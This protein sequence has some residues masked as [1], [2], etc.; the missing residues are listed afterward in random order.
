MRDPVSRV[1]RISIL[2]ALTST[3]GL[4]L[5]NATVASEA[6]E[7]AGD[8]VEAWLQNL[9][10]GFAIFAEGIAAGQTCSLELLRASGGACVISATDALGGVM[11]TDRDGRLVTSRPD[12]ADALPMAWVCFHGTCAGGI[13]LDECH[14]PDDPLASA[15]LSCGR[16]MQTSVLLGPQAVDSPPSSQLSLRFVETGS[17]RSGPAY[18][19]LTPTL[20][21]GDSGPRPLCTVVVAVDA[22]D[23]ELAAL[24]HARDAVNSSPDC[25]AAGV[26][27]EL[28]TDP[29]SSA[30][31][32]L[33]LGHVAAAATG[34]GDSFTYL[35]LSAPDL[36]AAQLIPAVHVV[37]PSAF[38]FALADLGPPEAYQSQVMAVV[39]HTVAGGATGDGQVTVVERTPVGACSIVTPTFAGQSAEML[40]RDIHLG[41]QAPGLPGP[42]SC[43]ASRNP[44]DV[45]FSGNRIITTLP[46]QIEIYV[47]DPGVGHTIQ[48]EGLGNV[49]PGAYCDDAMVECTGDGQAEI[50]LDASRSSDPDGDVLTFEWYEDYGRADEIFLGRGRTLA[51]PFGYGGHDI[52]VVVRDALG[53]QSAGGCHVRVA[54]TTPPTVVGSTVNPAVLYPANHALVGVTTAIDAFDTCSTA[55]ATLVTLTSSEPDDALGP[56]DGATKHDIQDAIPYTPDFQFHLRAERDST[57]AGRSYSAT[58][59]VRDDAGNAVSVDLTVEVPL[60]IGGVTD[61]ITVSV[62]KSVDPA[63]APTVEVVWTDTEG[64]REYNVARGDVR[65]ISETANHIYL[66]PVECLE[67]R[68]PTRSTQ[69]AGAISPGDVFFYL[70]EPIHLE[71]PGGF[72]GAGLGKPR[73]VDPCFYSGGLELIPDPERDSI[74]PTAGGWLVGVSGQHLGT[75]LEDFGER[76]VDVDWLGPDLFQSVQVVNAGVTYGTPAFLW[77]DHTETD[78]LS[79]LEK[80]DGRILDLE[81]QPRPSMPPLFTVSIIPNTGKRAKAWWWDYDLTPEEV[82]DAIDDYGM[83]II[84]LDAYEVLGE[85]KY[86]YVGVANVGVDA[87]AWW[88]YFNIGPD[89]VSQALADNNARLMD[90]E[91]HSNGNFSVVMVADDG[92]AW[93]WGA[94][95]TAQ[96]VGTFVNNKGS[97]LIDLERLVGEGEPRYAFVSIDNLSTDESKRL[98]SVVEQ[99]FDQSEFGPFFVTRGFLVKESSGPILA[100]MA[101]GLPF[102]PA[103]TLKLLP[104]LYAIQEVNAGDASL[105]GTTVS[106]LQDD[107]D[108]DAHCLPEGT[109]GSA[110][111]RDA[112]PTLIWYSH[113]RTLE[114]FFDKWDP[115][116]LI[117]PRAQTDWGMP[118]TAM[119]PGCTGEWLQ[120]RSTLYEL[121]AMFEGVQNLTLPLT[122]TPKLTPGSR[123]VFWNL[124]INQ[125][126]G[127]CRDFALGTPLCSCPSHE[128]DCSGNY[129]HSPYL[130]TG[131]GPA[132]VDFLAPM[133]LQ[134]GLSS[135]QLTDFLDEVLVRQKGGGA[136][137]YNSYTGASEG[138]RS[139]AFYVTLPFKDGAGNIVPRRFTLGIF[140]NDWD[141]T[142]GG[143]PDCQTLIDNEDVDGGEATLELFRLP[144]RMAVQTW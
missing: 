101:G 125:M 24:N 70:V 77:F 37:A 133:V 17:P 85:T 91:A 121:A 22:E 26:G 89:A 141:S 25:S 64:G 116:N 11:T 27:A 45:R 40:V 120:N 32:G 129:F 51:Y 124:L 56:T 49:P 7:F 112:L 78:V 81:P 132:T 96:Q 8:H 61:P 119:Y 5:V 10:E 123:Q 46:S 55:R 15:V 59:E 14:R 41:F 144:I 140:V 98:R 80:I 67:V 57:G 13:A 142:C 21:F 12:F 50:V 83:R 6:A 29:A 44:R 93:W 3:A 139:G 75:H 65:N 130:S 143:A 113:N 111:L 103:S 1:P 74:H 109:P 42:E 137:V 28:V 54:D 134:E 100:D 47:E 76:L 97:R 35:V 131:A 43:P 82:V 69:D 63:G 39:F 118:N 71:T 62:G 94:G 19:N 52:T 68:T 115:L 30:V 136:S 90:I 114:A 87:K 135:S 20:Q 126:Q 106:W 33:D 102:Q 2:L 23:D 99:A 18:F 86:S 58:Y 4:M 84:D 73:T 9:P 72:G 107:E 34:N 122:T 104:Y 128:P 38:H 117:T 66:G 127:N 31:Q 36:V 53:Q 105:D 48:P 16:S 110:S 88:L 79:R 138:Y 95:L 92:K 108:E 60:D